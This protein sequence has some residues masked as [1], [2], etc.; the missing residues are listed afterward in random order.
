MVFVACASLFLAPARAQVFSVTCVVPPPAR[1]AG[2]SLV[3]TLD[4]P[5]QRV[6]GWP[7]R[8]TGLSIDWADGHST[9]HLDRTRG[10]L[11]KR[12]GNAPLV[13]NCKK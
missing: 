4:F 2:L 12:A 7:A 5:Q 9:N 1:S 10:L 3:L 6:N 13:Y 8:I 11:T